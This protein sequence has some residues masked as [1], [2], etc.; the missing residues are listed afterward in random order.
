MYIMVPL[1]SACGSASES[2][3]F[4]SRAMR[5]RGVGAEAMQRHRPE[6]GSTTAAFSMA[7]FITAFTLVTV[8]LFA[9]HDVWRWFPPSIT[10]FGLQIDEQFH[11]TLWI[12]G[13]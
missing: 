7:L 4:G 11:R 2:R 5:L 6:S 13:V 8:Y 12:T 3:R 1:E 10:A 9:V